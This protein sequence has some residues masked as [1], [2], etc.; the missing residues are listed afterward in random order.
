MRNYVNFLLSDK[1]E[2]MFKDKDVMKE[3]NII[4]NERE[5]EYLIE[6]ME[7][8]YGNATRILYMDVSIGKTPKQEYLDSYN[9]H[10]NLLDKLNEKIV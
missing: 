2:E 10:K 7:V 8:G 5:L 4:L 6:T 1:G 9:F 3:Y